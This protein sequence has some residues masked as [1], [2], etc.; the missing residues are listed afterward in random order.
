MSNSLT[1]NRSSYIG[2]F[3]KKKISPTF[4]LFILEVALDFV[5]HKWPWQKEQTAAGALKTGRVFAV[6]SPPPQFVHTRVSPDI[7]RKMKNW[8]FSSISS[9]NV[10]FLLNLLWVSELYLFF[11]RPHSSPA[12]Y[13]WDNQTGSSFLH[14]SKMT[15]H[16]WSDKSEGIQLNHQS[17]LNPV[18]KYF[19]P[20]PILFS[21]F[22]AHVNLQYF[23]FDRFLG[24]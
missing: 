21:I 15:R 19:C 3:F 16:P 10:R 4:L 22:T 8:H 7:V 5:W 1:I 9:H 12:V 24:K 17:R 6:S 13:L 23:D 11:S 2:P 18:H 14:P 20:P